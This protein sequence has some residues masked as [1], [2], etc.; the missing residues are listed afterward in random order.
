MTAF[1][2]LSINPDSNEQAAKFIRARIRE[3]VKDPETAE[4]LVAKDYPIGTKR[5]CA[6]SFYFET[7][8]R[9]NVRL[10]DI[11]ANP[12]HEI[13]AAGVLAGEEEHQ[14]DVIVFATGFD[15]MTGTLLR[16]GITGRDGQTLNAK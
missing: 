16:I 7:Y 14:F 1:N 12:I 9:D 10:V 6:D 5:I 8:N 13:T 15:A 2:D 11:N 4:L 3:I